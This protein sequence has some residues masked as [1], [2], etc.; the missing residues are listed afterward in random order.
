MPQINRGY[1]LI[2]LLIVLLVST[3]L[4]IFLVQ[5][6]AI[7]QHH[8]ANTQISLR[9]VYDIQL[10]IDFLRNSVRHAGFTPCRSIKHLQLANTIQP[11]AINFGP[12]K[13][14]KIVRMGE[15][16][17]TASAILSKSSIMVRAIG[18]L[19]RHDAI[20]IAD[21]VHAEINVIQAIQRLQTGYK[22]ILKKSMQFN[23]VHAIYIGKWIEELFFIRRDKF[24]K[25]I[26]YY[27]NKHIE[28]MSQIIADWKMLL[29]QKHSSIL[30]KLKLLT[31]DHQLW[32][33]SIAVRSP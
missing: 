12:N 33:I 6:Y 1:G 2:E 22:I 4:M 11:I 26:F 13:A 5:Y 8:A 16:F 14:L 32:P 27:Q 29:L 20:L 30:L 7:S 10:I 18:D 19:H 9:Q 21:C 31:L 24:G 17:A 25:S 23:Y 28:A 15:F 3:Y